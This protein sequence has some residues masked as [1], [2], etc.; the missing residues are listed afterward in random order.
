MLTIG[1]IM[2]LDRIDTHWPD[3]AQQKL[4]QLLQ[5]LAPLP[6][7]EWQ[8]LRSHISSDNAARG[9]LLCEAGKN[10]S[11]L[12]FLASGVVRF[13]YLTEDGK[14]FNKAFARAGELVGP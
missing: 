8:W 2:M 12:H 14:E 10:P 11:A 13:Y 5:M 4:H 7:A 6:D 9:S 3:T 1:S